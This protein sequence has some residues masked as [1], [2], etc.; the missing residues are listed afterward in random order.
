MD[1]GDGRVDLHRVEF[2]SKNQRWL[3]ETNDASVRFDFSME[4]DGLAWAVSNDWIIRENGHISSE[5]QEMRCLSNFALTCSH[6]RIK[7]FSFTQESWTAGI[8]T[9]WQGSVAC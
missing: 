3:M 9:G 6:D 4:S 5:S 7:L 2:L 1:V 8:I